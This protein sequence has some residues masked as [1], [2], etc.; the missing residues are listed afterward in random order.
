MA[1]LMTLHP[2]RVYPRVCGGTLLGG[3]LGAAMI[4]LS[5]RVRGNPRRR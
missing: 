2:P 3:S 4:G 5:P 1:T